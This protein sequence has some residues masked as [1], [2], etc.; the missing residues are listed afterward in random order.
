[1]RPRS[2]DSVAEVQGLMGR[3]DVEL[4]ELASQVKLDV[5]CGQVVKQPSAFT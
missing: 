3:V 5:V 2:L 1:M 4:V